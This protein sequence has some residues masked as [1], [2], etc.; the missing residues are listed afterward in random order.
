M[1]RILLSLCLIVFLSASAYAGPLTDFIFLGTD[2][3]QYPIQDFQPNKAKEQLILAGRST[4]DMSTW[5][6]WEAYCS[7]ESTFHVLTSSTVTGVALPLP[8]TTWFG[9]G[10]YHGTVKAGTVAAF[11]SFSTTGT[12]KLIGM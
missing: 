12:C 11:T 10:V 9:M 4:I 2:S 5:V 1:K 3:E 6:H 7:V 8:A